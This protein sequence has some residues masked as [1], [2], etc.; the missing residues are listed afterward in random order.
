MVVVTVSHL[1]RVFFTG[2]FTGERR[3]NWWIGLALLACVLVSVF[4]GYLLPWDQLSY[5]AI[6]VCT[7]MLE[8]V[9]G[10][11]LWLQEVAR[12]G[13][14]V[15]GMAL[16]NFFTLHTSLVPVAVVVLL[17]FHF[18][19]VRKA[20]GV[21]LPAPEDGGSISSDK[22]VPSYP[23]LVVREAAVALGLTAVI[24]FFSV[25]IDAPLGV[26]AN[27]GLS[28]NP[29]K[30]PWYFLGV[31]ELLIHFQP[32][33]AVV[34]IPGLAVLGLIALP[35]LSPVSEQEGVWFRSEIGVRV[36]AIAAVLGLFLTAGAIVADDWLYKG[37]SVLSGVPT[38]LSGGVLPL[39][40]VL[41]LCAGFYLWVRRRPGV[42]Q[43]E[44][45]QSIFVFLMVC[46]VVL[47]ASGIWFRE[48]GMALVWPGSVLP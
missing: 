38:W 26:P 27:P 45:S 42:T 37:G 43:A 24:L 46:F 3:S 33:F 34:V 19:R 18:W 21:I 25:F 7:S 4:T 36:S 39:A 13:P 28:P 14:E 30:A 47:T 40:L 48:A 15:G 2:A 20:R 9:P 16:R 41:G 10:I 29:A 23:N 11:G 5:W 8:Y 44:V 6:T 31:Q 22:R 1:L 12:G 32:V 17:G 35:F